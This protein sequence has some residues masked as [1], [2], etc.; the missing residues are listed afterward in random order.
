MSLISRR[1]SKQLIFYPQ[2]WGAL[3]PEA[4]GLSFGLIRAF[5]G[6]GFGR[7]LWFWR[8]LFGAGVEV[9][10]DTGEEVGEGGLFFGGE[11]AEDE[12][13]VAK[14]AAEVVV[15]GAEAKARE[16]G[17]VERFGDG[18]E[19]VVATAATF[20]A[21]A[22]GAEGEVEIVADDE[23]VLEGDFVE[24]DELLDGAAGIVVESLGL[25]EDFVAGFEPEG[26]KLGFLPVEMVDFGIKIK[27]EE[28]EIV[29]REIVFGAGITEADDEFHEDIITC[30]C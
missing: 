18:F 10:G 17:G 3:L 20:G 7:I 2:M 6:Y 27:G 25:D 28:A 4:E 5:V 26:V 1:I 12:V 19:T 14:G 24:I 15:A 21:V 8:L 11:A 29:A 22:R 23:D 9:A 13:D 30:F 16:I